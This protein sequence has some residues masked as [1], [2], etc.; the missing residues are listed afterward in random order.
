MEK[1]LTQSTH[2]NAPADPMY[3]HPQDVFYYP[4]GDRIE[5]ASPD[6][7]VA[8]YM[9]TYFSGAGP[10]KQEDV[11]DSAGFEH[12]VSFTAANGVKHGIY[13]ER[14]GDKWVVAATSEVVPPDRLTP[15]PGTHTTTD[16]AATTL[17]PGLA[18][19]QEAILRDAVV[20]SGETQSG[21]S[22]DANTLMK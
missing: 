20:L 4:Q 8:A 7:G 21:K 3:Q 15:N 19:R 17:S 1:I 6:E 16:S 9:R 12:A 10:V 13:L 2:L 18:K 11:I 22:W 14:S 5:Y